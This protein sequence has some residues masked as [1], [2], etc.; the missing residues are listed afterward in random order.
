MLCSRKTVIETITEKVL[1]KPSF[2]K[3]NSPFLYIMNTKYSC[4]RKHAQIDIK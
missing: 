1:S 4:R 3:K 2:V